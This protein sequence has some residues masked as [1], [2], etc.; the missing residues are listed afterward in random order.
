MSAE[1]PRG[2]VGNT[3]V[4]FSR[5]LAAYFESPI[6]YV[7]AAVFLM[8]TGGVFMNGFFL[9][10]RLSMDA[11]FRFLPFVLALF[12]PAVTMRSWA[13]ERAQGTF[14]LLMTLPFK[15]GEVVCGKY[16]AAF[17]FY[18]AVLCGSAVIPVMLMILGKPDVSIIFTSYLG[19]AALGAF[20][21]ALGVW[22]S[23]I[24]KEQIVAFTVAVFF[25]ALFLLSGHEKVVEVLD[26][27]A[28]S[29]E[30]GTRIAEYLSVLPHY[31]AFLRG[32]VPLADVFYFVA[33]ST[34]FLFLNG[35][36]VRTARR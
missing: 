19:A 11:Y 10:G 4:V 28:P 15:T 35:V 7:F 24:T 16:L 2:A 17:A 21:L 8:L 27:L 31:E 5:E 22:V 25:S 14:E 29:R 13:E 20:Y 18:L 23:S 12:I 1:R 9:D 3:S 6:A 34:A 33:L 26:G 32:V 36:V 30:I